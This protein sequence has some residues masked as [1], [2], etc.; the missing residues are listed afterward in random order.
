MEHSL[1]QETLEMQKMQT[2]QELQQV[3]S[4]TLSDSTPGVDLMPRRAGPGI[5]IRAALVDIGA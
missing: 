4:T 1:A 2:L 5:G 3:K